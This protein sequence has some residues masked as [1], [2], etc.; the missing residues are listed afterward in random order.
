MCE[1][2]KTKNIVL[3]WKRHASKKETR[4]TYSKPGGKQWKQHTRYESIDEESAFVQ[5]MAW[6]RIGGKTPEPMIIYCIDRIV[7]YQGLYSLSGKTSYRQISRSLEA[8]R[9]GF[10]MIVSLWHLTGISAAVLPRC[11]SNFRAMGQI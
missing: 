10:I 1:I 11:L 5:E 2:S 9:L 7:H 6:P 8:A 3:I 4:S